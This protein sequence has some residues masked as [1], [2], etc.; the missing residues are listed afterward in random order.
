MPNRSTDSHPTE[1]IARGIT[2]GRYEGILDSSRRQGW[3]TAVGLVKRPSPGGT[4][5]GEM[6]RNRPFP[7]T[8]AWLAVFHEAD[9]RDPVTTSLLLLA[10]LR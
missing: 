8:A 4:A 10:H 1:P 7:E 9:V 5:A 2:N 3:A 6:R